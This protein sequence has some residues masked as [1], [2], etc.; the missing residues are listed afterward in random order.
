M[1]KRRSREGAWI[2][3]SWR[4]AKRNHTGI[5]APVRERGLKSHKI[6]LCCCL[7]PVAPVRERGLKYEVIK[8]S[9]DNLSRSREGA[10]IEIGRIFCWCGFY[11][12]APVRERGLKSTKSHFALVYCYGRSREGAW[13]EIDIRF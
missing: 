8:L 10:W 12:V 1:I 6:P 4:T 13:I 7:L 2:E 9:L 11:F 5:V 3:I